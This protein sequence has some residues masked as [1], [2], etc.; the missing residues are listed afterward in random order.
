MARK[1][2]AVRN[3]EQK[4]VAG[5]HCGGGGVGDRYTLITCRKV[6]TMVRTSLVVVGGQDRRQGRRKVPV[7]L[8]VEKLQK[9]R[10]NSRK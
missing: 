9:C 8:G 5:G 2:A 1:A 4:A 10:E 6:V 3:G 7:T